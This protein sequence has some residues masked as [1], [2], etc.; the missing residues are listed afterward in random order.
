VTTIRTLAIPRLDCP[1]PA[2]ISPHAEAVHAH[3]LEWV[4]KFELVKDG[5]SFEHLSASRFGRLAARAYPGAPLER[6][7]IVSDWNTWLFVLDDQCDEM[8]I[9]KQPSKLAALHCKCL[10]ILSGGM[11]AAGDIAVIHG[12]HDLSTRI[13]PL[14]PL[15]WLTRFMHSA[16]EY[17]EA[18]EW[19]AQNRAQ[20]TWPD[21]S[22]YI[23][24]RPFTGGLYTDIDLV[25]LT[26][27][28]ALPLTVRIHPRIRQFVTITNN[29]VC[30][31]NDIFSLQKERKHRDMHNLALLIHRHEHVGLQEAVDRVAKLIEAQ[32]RR[33][34]MLEKNLPGF[35]TAV[36]G[37]VSRFIG[38]MRSWMRGNLD[39]SY[40]SARYR[41]ADEAGV[42]DAAQPCDNG[43]S[44]T[45]TL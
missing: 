9:G 29:V 27:N 15:A 37:D 26:E 41:E 18:T 42:F 25:E 2:A 32:M 5:K 4:Q 34:V 31:S 6:L 39:W 43:E 40:E 8:G 22:T 36:D 19:E 13:R 23:H 30:W 1:F 24:M 20:G 45:T 33:F 44:C 10:E 3:T 7:E 35:G 38:V 14:M 16:A 21:T 12:L 11:P 17:F 28:L